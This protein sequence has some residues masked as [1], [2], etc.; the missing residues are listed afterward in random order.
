MDERKLKI[1]VG[2]L[3]A[4]VI[5]LLVVDIAA[6]VALMKVK[7][8]AASSLDQVVT[9]LE[10]QKNKEIEFS[11]PFND[12]LKIPVKNLSKPVTVSFDKTVKVHVS[13][14]IPIEIH[15]YEVSVPVNVL[16]RVHIVQNITTTGYDENGNQVTIT[17]PLDTW[18]DVPISTTV[19]VPIDISTTTHFED[20]IDVPVQGSFEVRLDE[21][22]GITDGTLEVPISTDYTVKLTPKQLGLDS[23]ID[24]LIETLKA[25]QA[26]LG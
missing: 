12:T 3:T 6:V 7:N 4:V 10:E 25:I 26:S 17:V 13:K 24:Q 8:R 19:T 11:I 18:V 22:L 23:L 21:I 2:V 15:D 14:D 9:Q 20:T 16:T 1:W 5:F